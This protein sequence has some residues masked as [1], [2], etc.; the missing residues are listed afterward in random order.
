MRKTILNVIMGMI[1][2]GSATIAFVS[3]NPSETA[4]WTVAAIS[5]A[6]FLADQIGPKYE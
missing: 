1:L 4:G 2:A 3:E 6:I 5:A